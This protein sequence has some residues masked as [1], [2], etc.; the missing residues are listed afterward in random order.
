MNICDYCIHKQTCT[1]KPLAT[2]KCKDF[3]DK[4]KMTLFDRITAT[5]ETLA[6]KLVFYSDSF[7]KPA[8]L[9]NGSI[10]ICNWESLITGKFYLTKSEAI[11]ATVA[12]LKA[13]V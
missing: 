8:E 7:N 4:P 11:A 2:T 12:K 10:V 9:V 6:E 13:V 3:E 1:N 5:P